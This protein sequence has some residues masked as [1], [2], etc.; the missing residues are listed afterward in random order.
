MLRVVLRISMRRREI[1]KLF[2]VDSLIP[3]LVSFCQIE[4]R[5]MR[6]SQGRK[7]IAFY[8]VVGYL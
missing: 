8:Y 2:K 1:T 4:R 3:P 6:V 7:R 5:R